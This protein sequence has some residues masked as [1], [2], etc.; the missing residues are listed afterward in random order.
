MSQALQAFHWHFFGCGLAAHH[1]SHLPAGG[2]FVGFGGAG[3][4]LGGAGVGLGGAGVGLNGEG[5][6]MGQSVHEHLFSY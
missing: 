1:C 5:V 3:V 2:G 4:G 6:G